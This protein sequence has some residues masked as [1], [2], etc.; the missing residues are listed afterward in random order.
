MK[1]HPPQHSFVCDLKPLARRAA[2]PDG[3]TPLIL[4]LFEL[5]R[6]SLW[7]PDPRIFRKGSRDS[8]PVEK[9]M[10]QRQTGLKGVLDLMKGET[11]FTPPAHSS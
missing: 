10:F 3:Y 5:K 9:C 4:Y 1:S 8:I 2:V 11:E 7:Q 6:G